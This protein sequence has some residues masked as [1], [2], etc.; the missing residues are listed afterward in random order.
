MT[1]SPQLQPADQE[2]TSD[3]SSRFGRFVL[4][5][6]LSED[7]EGQ[8]Y[9]AIHQRLRK[10]VALKLLS[11]RHDD[12]VRPREK[13]LS[14]FRVL[15][16]LSHPN[17][18]RVETA[19]EQNGTPYLVLEFVPGFDLQSVVNSVGPLAIADACQLIGQAVIGLGYLHKHQLIHGH[20]RPESLVLTPSAR[21]KL[22]GLER[23]GQPD[24]PPQSAH[25]IRDLARVF[26]DLVGCPVACI[27][28]ELPTGLADAVQR[29]L[30]ADA[31]YVNE[32]PRQ[33]IDVLAKFSVG[34][35]LPQL[36]RRLDMT[37]EPGS[38][39][40]VMPG[41][42]EYL[43][44][45]HP[46]VDQPT[47]QPM[48]YVLVRTLAIAAILIVCTA[49]AGSQWWTSGNPVRDSPARGR[50]GLSGPETAPAKS[51]LASSIDDPGWTSSAISPTSDDLHRAYDQSGQLLAS[52]DPARDAFNIQMRSTDRGTEFENLESRG[53]VQFPV[54]MPERYTL[55]Y[56]VERL[57]GDGSFGFG[58]SA[59]EGRMIALI[60]HKVD[61]RWQSGIFSVTSEGNH[62]IVDPYAEQI[63][64]TG[65]PV[66]LTLD[67]A[68]EHVELMRFS[69]SEADVPMTK[70]SRWTASNTAS[71]STLPSLGK[72]DAYYPQA[73][74]VH[75]FQGVFRVSNLQ[76]VA[77]SADPVPQPFH[78][79]EA[80]IESRLAQRIVWRGGHVEIITDTGTRTVHRLQELTDDPWL[81]GV[82]KCP[83]ATG[84]MIGDSEMSQ[85]TAINGIRKL[86]L[87]DSQVTM[88]GLSGIAG[89]QSLNLLALP[90]KGI[91]GSVLASMRDLPALR[92]LQLIGVSL[93]DDDM[94][95]LARFPKLTSLCLSGCPIADEAVQRVARLLP[96]LQHLCLSGTRISGDCLPELASLRSLK[97]LQLHK[98]SV[99]DGAIANLPSLPQLKILTLKD[100]RVSSAAIEKIQRE[101]PGIEVQ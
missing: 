58:F 20:I 30:S 32:T 28:D 60:D 65:L 21:L 76:I 56:T 5:E 31:E 64:T 52:L 95:E 99:D 12:D 38:S 47:V 97:D 45:V 81:V 59:G 79:S 75:T 62:Q 37:P 17:L 53:I 100:S 2:T 6:L 14:Q 1:Q 43:H 96:D 66:R 86:D 36:L 54:I 24:S 4:L 90:R 15:C 19:G 57:E 63:L 72:T 35:D 9:R 11:P 50:V 69:S 92:Q 101:R 85:L 51:I 98:T 89:L 7:T 13:Y 61:E 34:C 8:L 39:D 91:D 26:C 3:D 25:D 70:I 46:Q 48:R 23:A 40:D 71:S 44:A 87:T 16:E 80:P 93:T 10:Q 49:L 84:L 82:E 83:G 94:D 74:F 68:P 27:L 42:P 22:V 29:L 67:V 88:E 77:S 41:T 73:F 78:G 55:Q 33:F 18:V